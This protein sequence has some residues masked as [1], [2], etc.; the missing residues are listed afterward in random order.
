MWGEGFRDLGLRVEGL[1]F[2]N[3]SFKNKVQDPAA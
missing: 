1:G 3:L 2:E